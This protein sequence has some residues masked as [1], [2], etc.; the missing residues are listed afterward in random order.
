MRPARAAALA[1]VRRVFEQ[2]AYADRA[3]AAEAE[4]LDPRERALAMQIAYGTV[5]RRRTL[6]HVAQGLVRRPLATLEPAVLAGIRIGLFQLL[7]LA[8]IPD[9]AA[10]GET[11]EL[12]KRSSPGGAGLVNAVLRRAARERAPLLA[13]LPDDTPAGAA[14]KH[15]VPDW[16]AELWWEELGPE[17][18]RR[19]LR[20]VNEPA[21]TAVRVNTLLA[22]ADEVR[23]EL[24]VPSRGAP[25]LPEGLVLDGAFDIP[26]SPLF[27]GGLITPQSRGSMLV[28]RAL[29]PQPG[30]ETLDLCAAPGAKTTHLAALMQRRGRLVAVERQPARARVLVE[31]CRRMGANDVEVRAE[32][33]LALRD[34]AQF[35]RVLLDPPCSGLGTLQSRPDRRWHASAEALGEL[36]ELQAGLLGVAAAATRPGGH[37]VYSVCTISRRQGGDLIDAFLGAEPEWEAVDLGARYPHW[38]QDDRGR[39][40]QLLPDRDGT[41]G[42]FIACLRRTG[43]LT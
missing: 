19:L 26:G 8:G 21:E 28:A 17:R 34:E 7:Y 39:Y 10:V 37:L 6:D 42:F 40:L 35:D 24:P 20:A 33:A 16:L 23:A 9:H 27:R 1:T 30:E 25:E 11:V 18:A 29:D 41:D 38:R 12:V 43:A 22:T 13:G 36:A 2:G 4:G 14:L 15:S 3:L 32:D 31:T 5:Q